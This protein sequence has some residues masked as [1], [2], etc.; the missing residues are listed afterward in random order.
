[1]FYFWYPSLIPLLWI[2]IVLVIYCSRFSLLSSTQQ[3][4]QLCDHPLHESRPSFCSHNL[5]QYHEPYDGLDEHT[6]QLNFCQFSVP[7]DSC[8]HYHSSFNSH[9]RKW[10][11]PPKPFS[12]NQAAKTR[13]SKT[14]S[15]MLI[16]QFCWF[17]SNCKS[18]YNVKNTSFSTLTSPNI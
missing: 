14:L 6:M 12:S 11:C 17:S 2:S 13:D 1:M 8:H 15:E 9:S 16:F 5:P 3:H 7:T 10:V 4:S 18:G